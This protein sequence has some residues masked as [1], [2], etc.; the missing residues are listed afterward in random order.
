MAWSSLIMARCLRTLQAVIGQEFGP[1]SAEVTIHGAGVQ[2]D[3]WIDLRYLRD[4][5]A[6]EPRAFA[7]TRVVSVRIRYIRRKPASPTTAQLG[8]LLDQ[9][10]RLKYLLIVNAN[11]SSG[12][13]IDGQIGP[14]EAQADLTDLG[15]SADQYEGVEILW[16]CK[17]VENIS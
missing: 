12:N 2:G 10:D 4:D 15:E 3:R 1:A 9:V 13:W 14:C 11:H 8:E 7:S 5:Q 16:T 17:M 6:I